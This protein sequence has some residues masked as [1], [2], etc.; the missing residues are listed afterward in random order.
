M[1][2][3]VLVVDDEEP[4]RR[5]VTRMLSPAYTLLTAEDGLEAQRVFQQASEGIDLVLTDVF[6]PGMNG[7]E[8]AAKLRNEKPSVPIL[9]MTGMRDEV[10]ETEVFLRKPFTPAMLRAAVRDA[11][12]MSGRKGGG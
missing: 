3:V 4:I 6:M 11:L 5:L 10:S 9:F 7:I 2:P 1:G 8:L 12:T